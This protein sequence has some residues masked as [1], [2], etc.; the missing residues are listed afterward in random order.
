MAISYQGSAAGTT[1]ATIPSHAADDLII[2]F[3]FRDGNANAPT[4][5]GG[6]TTIENAAGANS[7]GAALAYKVALSS[8]ETSGTWSNA[9]TLIVHVYRGCATGDPIGD[10]AVDTAASTT[11]NYP[12]LASMQVTD[13]TSWVV[14]FAGHRSIDTN[15]QNAPSG[16]TNRISELDG[17]DEA[18]GHDTN[19]GVTSWTG[20]TVAVGG[21]SSGWRAMTVEIL[22]AVATT[23]R[24][25]LGLMG[26][27]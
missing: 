3:A 14:G 24:D 11:V 25:R 23:H 1:T 27:G 10:H 2:G 12:T 20:T 15:V 22:A 5:P 17:T 18:A 26:V 8:G 6:W 9:N 13:G 7:A 21:T 4:I 19:G 16:M